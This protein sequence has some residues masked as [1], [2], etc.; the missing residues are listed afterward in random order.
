[1]IKFS[2]PGTSQLAG[3]ILLSQFCVSVAE[4]MLLGLNLLL[5]LGV[6]PVDLSHLY[7]GSMGVVKLAG[8][9]AGRLE[10]ALLSNCGD[11]RCVYIL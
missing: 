4:F 9:G 1:M 7:L 6:C 8:P 3:Q 10:I 5:C 11:F 2:Y